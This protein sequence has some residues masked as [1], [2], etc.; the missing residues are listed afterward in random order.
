MGEALELEVS[1]NDQ[2]SVDPT[3]VEFEVAE[4]WVSEVSELGFV[5]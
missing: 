2:I 5:D 3:V 4:F 1:E